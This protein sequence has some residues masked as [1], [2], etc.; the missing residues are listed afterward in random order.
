MGKQVKTTKKKTTKPRQQTKAELAR[1]EL[2]LRGN[3]G[4]G[5]QLAFQ[6]YYTP[7][8][9]AAIVAEIEEGLPINLAANLNRIPQGTVHGWIRRGEENPDGTFGAFAADVRE[10]QARFV[11]RAINGIKEAGFKNTQQWTALMTLLERIYPE[12]FRRPDQR[13][14]VNVNVAVGVVEKK[15][16]ELHAAGEIVYDGN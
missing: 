2:G 10:A 6:T 11:K 4:V 1:Q 7:E 14:N 9:G 12:N 8:I 13:S 5:N 3:H 16:H 15:L